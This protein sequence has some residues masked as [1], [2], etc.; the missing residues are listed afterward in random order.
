[1]AI[2][3]IVARIDSDAQAEAGALLDAARAASERT[4][5][6]ATDRAESRAAQA[7]E[8]GR[9]A[10]EREASTLRAAAR[11]AARDRM[12]AAR[13]ELVAEALKRVE[14]ELAALPDAEYAR[15][16]ARE[17]ARTSIPSGV[18]YLGHADAARLRAALPAALSAAGIDV[19]IAEASADIERGVV[20]VGDRVRIEV[21]PASIIEADR[22]E[23]EAEV[24]RA[25][26]G[27]EV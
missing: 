4:I 21:S 7:R 24:D 25:L 5:A 27:E 10:A 26:F 6:E 23:L 20:L 9:S 19:E 18:L 1:M 15:L 2:D 22:G 3:D 8:R 13:Q 16:L 17:L 14:A 12:L 11:L